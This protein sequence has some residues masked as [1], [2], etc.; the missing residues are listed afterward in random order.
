MAFIV[1]FLSSKLTVA[2]PYK[3]SSPAKS[4]GVFCKTV[5]ATFY[6]SYSRGGFSRHY[7][8][9]FLEATCTNAD[10]AWVA[11]CVCSVFA[12]TKAVVCQVYSLAV[13]S[14]GLQYETQIQAG[15]QNWLFYCFVMYIYIYMYVC[16]AND[17]CMLCCDTMCPWT[18][19][20]YSS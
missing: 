11:K 4:S 19:M 12:N 7:T 10:S 18:R 3:S 2:S 1:E 6:Y 14:T 9:Y 16:V 17:I 8:S 20:T 5:S 15:L 13:F